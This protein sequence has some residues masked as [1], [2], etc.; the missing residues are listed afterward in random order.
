MSHL[1]N[2]TLSFILVS[3]LAGTALAGE[4][5]GPPGETNAP[6]CVPGEM[7]SPPCTSAS[8]SSDSVNPGEVNGPPASDSADLNTIIEAAFLALF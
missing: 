5:N 7:N 2:L 4:N 3:V 6:P 8:V 1:K